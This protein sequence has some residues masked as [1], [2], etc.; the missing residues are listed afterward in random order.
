MGFG[1]DKQ[2]K[3]ADVEKIKPR[4]TPNTQKDLDLQKERSAGAAGIEGINA[5]QLKKL[6]L[7][8]SRH[9][10]EIKCL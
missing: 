9:A 4:N 2:L 10:D 6:A 1:Y 5:S 3:K 7:D 8:L